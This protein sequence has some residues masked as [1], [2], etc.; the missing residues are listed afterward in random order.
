MPH[1]LRDNHARSVHLDAQTPHTAFQRLAMSVVAESVA[2][3][4]ASAFSNSSGHEAPT[5]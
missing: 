5:R 4:A 3:A 2:A 1:D